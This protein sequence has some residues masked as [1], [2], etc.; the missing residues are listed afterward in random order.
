MLKAKPLHFIIYKKKIIFQ[1]ENIFKIFMLLSFQWLIRDHLFYKKKKSVKRDRLPIKI[2]FYSLC[3]NLHIFLITKIT[4]NVFLF[5]FF[6]MYFY[7]KNVTS[8]LPLKIKNTQIIIKSHV[9]SLI[10]KKTA[11]CLLP[12]KNILTPAQLKKN[13]PI[14]KNKNCTIIYKKNY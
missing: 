4:K 3:L 10:D 11:R 12:I 5:H 8:T 2:H 1:N 6:Y 7:I 13:F 9:P 14:V